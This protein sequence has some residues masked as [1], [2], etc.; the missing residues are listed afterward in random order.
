MSVSIG[1]LERIGIES[2]L[3]DHAW[4]LDHGA[5][6]TLHALYTENGK[7]SGVG[8]VLIGRQQIQ[9]WGIARSKLPRK[10]RHVVTNLRISGEE[11]GV[12]SVTSCLTLYRHDGEGVGSSVAFLVGDYDDRVV[13]DESGAWLFVERN[14]VAAFSNEATTV[15]A[16]K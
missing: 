6:E 14:I 15:G 16:A 12:V 11:D 7:I 8:P 9:E 1:A 5:A 3:L 13:R 2:L 10:T 4:R